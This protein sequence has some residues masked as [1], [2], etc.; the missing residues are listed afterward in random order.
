[1]T[2]V[3]VEVE[4]DRI[5][6]DFGDSGEPCAWLW[7]AARKAEAALACLG[8]GVDDGIRKGEN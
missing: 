5:D 7:D 3:H 8:S 2:L 4:N 6:G 1:M